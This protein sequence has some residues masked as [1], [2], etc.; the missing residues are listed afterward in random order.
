M[1]VRAL[2]CESAN[3][4]NTFTIPI[5]GHCIL[6]FNTAIILRIVFLLSPMYP[7]GTEGFPYSEILQFDP[8]EQAE[9]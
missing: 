1:G 5:H 8:G 6:N 3:T 4:D 9:G 2:F 7:V